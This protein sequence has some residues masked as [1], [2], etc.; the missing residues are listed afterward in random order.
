MSEWNAEVAEWYAK[1]Y[2]D[3]PTNQLGVDQL[4]LQDNSVI[5]DIGCGTGSALRY[6]ASQMKGGQLI[7]IDPVPRMI[8]IAIE[9]TEGHPSQDRIEFRVGPAEKLPLEDS[10]AD[11][12]LAFDSI[13]HWGNVEKGLAEV[14]RVLRPGGSFAVVKD[15]GTPKPQDSINAAASRLEAAGFGVDDPS[16]ISGKEVE[17]FL[18]ISQIGPEAAAK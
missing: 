14:K 10:L 17:F 15:A 4:H 1:K 12:V 11:W 18:L 2:G 7:G 9:S 8:E 5:V 16:K 6:A 3:Y 13:D